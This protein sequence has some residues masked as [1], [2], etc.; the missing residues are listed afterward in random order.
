MKTCVYVALSAALGVSLCLLTVLTLTAV[1][2]AYLTHLRQVTRSN[3]DLDAMTVQTVS[4]PAVTAPAVTTTSAK[5]ATTAKPVL[6]ASITNT[7]IP[8]RRRM[9]PATPNILPHDPSFKP[10]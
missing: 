4:V 9:R 7:P 2:S 5:P 1:A 3:T 10:Q 6:P 8:R